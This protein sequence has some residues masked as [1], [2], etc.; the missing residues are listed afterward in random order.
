MKSLDASPSN[1][2]SHP[3]LSYTKGN[4]STN[5]FVKVYHEISSDDNTVRIQQIC[6]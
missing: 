5:L 3:P 1:Y 6:A 2:I 4:V